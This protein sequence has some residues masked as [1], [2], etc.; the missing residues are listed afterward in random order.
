[1][2]ESLP[3][4]FFLWSMGLNGSALRAR[5]GGG[6]LRAEKAGEGLG[7][8]DEASANWE[9]SRTR[10]SLANFGASVVFGSTR[11]TRI[12][13][14]TGLR[15]NPE[16]DGANLAGEARKVQIK[17]HQQT[18]SFSPGSEFLDIVFTG[19][20]LKAALSGNRAGQSGPFQGARPVPF[21]CSNYLV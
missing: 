1:V 17:V 15:I 4:V 12:R 10:N 6:A 21:S 11:L 19:N 16:S 8:R 13:M 3:P 20:V 14:A 5:P 2:T 9:E 18:L 7:L